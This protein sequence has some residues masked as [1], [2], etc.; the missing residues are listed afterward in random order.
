[1]H[2]LASL[3]LVAFSQ[4][5]TFTVLDLAIPF[6]DKNKILQK[7]PSPSYLRRYH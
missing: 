7:S 4:A 5:S 3:N 2:F 6:V 1:M